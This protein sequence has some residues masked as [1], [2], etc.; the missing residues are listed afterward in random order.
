MK[1]KL[2]VIGLVLILAA[3]IAAARGDIAA[4]TITG[5]RIAA[6]TIT[7]D[8]LNVSTLD[9]IT[10]NV[11]TLTGGTIDGVTVRAG[12]GDEVTLDS[13]GVTFAAGSGSNNRVKWSDGN[14]VLS[15]SGNLQV[16]GLAGGT[17]YVRSNGDVALEAGLD[18]SGIIT[19]SGAGAPRIINLGGTGSTSF[20]CTDNSGNLYSQGSTCDGSVPEIA[21]LRA[22]VAELRALVAQLSNSQR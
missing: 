11:G 12:S 6:N 4:G 17:T 22:E 21:A 5:D 2:T 10:A 18:S 16:E 9:A 14:A 3:S 8:R 7:A 15:D 1:M 13:S 20:V 19:L